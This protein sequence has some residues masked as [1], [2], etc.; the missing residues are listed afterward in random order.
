MQPD[1]GRGVGPTIAL[2]KAWPLC[3]FPA[4]SVPEQEAALVGLGIT[5]DEDVRLW[6]RTPENLVDAGG[7][8]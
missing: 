4:L 2:A 5:L 6:Q 3:G 8:V 1:E 7:T